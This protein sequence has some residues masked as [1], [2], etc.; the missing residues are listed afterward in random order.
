M[1]KVTNH[2]WIGNP[3]DCRWRQQVIRAFQL[4]APPR[5]YVASRIAA[6]PYLHGQGRADILGFIEQQQK[7]Q[8]RQVSEKIL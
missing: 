6:Q 4:R 8:N 2:R 1:P 7:M 5:A 3:W